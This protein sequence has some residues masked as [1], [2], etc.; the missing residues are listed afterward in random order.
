MFG[1]SRANFAVGA[2][3]DVPASL[4]R[5]GV[6]GTLL[7][8]HQKLRSM[9]AVARG[10][11]CGLLAALQGERAPIHRRQLGCSRRFAAGQSL[12]RCRRRVAPQRLER[13][14]LGDCFASQRDVEGKHSWCAA[15]LAVQNSGEGV[16]IEDALWAQRYALVR[17]ARFVEL[18]VDVV[19]Q[20]AHRGAPLVLRRVGGTS[21]GVPREGIGSPTSPNES[22]SS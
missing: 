12:E 15:V 7:R 2:V 5:C 22:G 21:R 1:G 13:A 11:R 19:V 20:V 4:R 9:R 6:R 17:V 10:A 18:G 14:Q 3:L 16:G 8:N